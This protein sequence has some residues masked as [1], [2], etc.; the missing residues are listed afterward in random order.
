MGPGPGLL[1]AGAGD[2]P[3]SGAFTCR[4][5]LF[6]RAVTRLFISAAPETLALALGVFRPYFLLFPALGVTVLSTYFLQATLQGR[7]AALLAV[8]R[9]FL[10][11]GPLVLLLPLALG[12]P[13]VW[14]ALPVSECLTAA[15]ALRMAGGRPGGSLGGKFLDFPKKS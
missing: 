3:G 8:L 4:G 13:G 9:S 2:L 11:A 12:L 1:A 15:A 7:R 6:P 14:L 5:E 10:T